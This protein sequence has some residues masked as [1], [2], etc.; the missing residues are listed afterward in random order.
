MTGLGRR[1]VLSGTLP[2]LAACTGMGASA[3][4]GDTTVTPG[5]GVRAGDITPLKIARLVASYPDHLAGIEGDTLIWTDGTR[6]PIG[7]GQPPRPFDEMLRS[8]SLADQLRQMYEPGP[9]HGPPPF[10]YSPGRLRN[11]AFFLKMYGDC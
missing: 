10:N 2:V 3:P 9:P 6:M 7:G 8:A 11:T 4:E 5:T 1:L